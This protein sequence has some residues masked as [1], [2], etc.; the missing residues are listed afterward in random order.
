MVQ[1]CANKASEVR[2]RE[3]GERNRRKFDLWS[4]SYEFLYSPHGQ[5]RPV[6]VHGCAGEGDSII[7]G[8]LLKGLANTAKSRD[9][10]CRAVRR[11]KR[12]QFRGYKYKDELQLQGHTRVYVTSAG[13]AV[14]GAGDTVTAVSR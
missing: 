12:R 10:F 5:F 7:T 6:R 8:S 2:G 1:T 11:F 4:F 13:R 3:A 14:N 9:L